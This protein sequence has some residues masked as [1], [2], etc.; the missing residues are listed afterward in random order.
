MDGNLN[1][2]GNLNE[3]GNLNADVNLNADGG[4][5]SSRD[6]RPDVREY[7]AAPPLI[8]RDLIN[9][10]SQNLTYA[11]YRTMRKRTSNYVVSYSVNKFEGRLVFLLIW[12]CLFLCLDKGNIVMLQPDGHGLGHGLVPSVEERGCGFVGYTGP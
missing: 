11:L 5:E 6:D 12:H 2:H 9:V 3:D 8:S 1:V 7:K 4:R 10:S